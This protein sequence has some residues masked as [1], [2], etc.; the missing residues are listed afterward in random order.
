[1]AEKR[2]SGGTSLRAGWALFK[3]NLGFLVGATVIALAISLGVS[4]LGDMMRAQMPLLSLFA[5][6]ISFLVNGLLIMGMSTIGLKL[7]DG[8]RP[9]LA[10]M[11]CCLSKIVTY[12]VS[13]LVYTLVVLA[14]LVLLVV[15]GII[16][17]VMFMFYAL[18]IVDTETGPLAALRQSA[19][20]GKGVR[21][22]LFL[23]LLVLTG[24]NIAGA[25]ALLVGLLFT[26]PFS[27]LVMAHA[28]RALQPRAEGVTAAPGTELPKLIS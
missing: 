23:L 2:F 13:S 5:H 8:Q 6:V 25:V 15:P 18:V 10:D 1:M 7:V 20:L 16:W 22:E 26:V 27:V 14:G 9:E 24:I 12:A 11:F 21:W 17:L 3:Q 28:Y 4:S 19:R